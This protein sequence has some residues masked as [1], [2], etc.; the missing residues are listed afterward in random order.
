MVNTGN[1][2]KYQSSST[3]ESPQSLNA[4]LANLAKRSDGVRSHERAR[5][6]P[7]C[8]V[9]IMHAGNL[10]HALVAGEFCVGLTVLRACGGY[11]ERG[12]A[13]RGECTTSSARGAG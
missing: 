4:L 3:L 12:G 11:P 13:C 9:C 10:T 6:G 7:V 5:E 1:I 8:K 2:A